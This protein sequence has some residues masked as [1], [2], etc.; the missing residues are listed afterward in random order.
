MSILA[1]MDGFDLSFG[2]PLDYLHQLLYGITNT[3]ADLYCDGPMKSICKDYWKDEKCDIAKL[4]ANA[5][6]KYVDAFK[7]HISKRSEWKSK[8][9][10][11]LLLCYKLPCMQDLLATPVFSTLQKLVTAAFI[12]LSSKISVKDD[13]ADRLL[14]D[15]V[16]EF[17]ELFG[18]CTFVHQFGSF[19]KD[20]MSFMG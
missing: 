11:S 2:F 7:S 6:S 9:F 16:Y 14:H 17:N 10:Q 3:I 18:S 5:P 4:D 13:I 15:F 1:D 8:E 19:S 20:V 12:L